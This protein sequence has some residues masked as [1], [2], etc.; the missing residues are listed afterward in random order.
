LTFPAGTVGPAFG[1]AFCAM[2]V[3]V[4]SGISGIA[5]NDPPIK[6]PVTCRA[7]ERFSFIFCIT[8]LLFLLLAEM[9]NYFSPQP[10]A[11]CTLSKSNFR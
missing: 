7:R 1:A 4:S 5:N 3:A 2:S 10:R 8:F 6:T 9:A 11:V